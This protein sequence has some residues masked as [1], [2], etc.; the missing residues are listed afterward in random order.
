MTSKIIADDLDKLAELV[1]FS[2]VLRL[3]IRCV[4]LD[5]REACLHV[6]CLEKVNHRTIGDDQAL[7]SGIDGDFSKQNRSY[8]I[9]TSMTQENNT[10][11][12]HTQQR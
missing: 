7:I 5:T 6:L 12:L 2:T 1:I 8:K 11:D 4:L 3:P 9:A 10:L